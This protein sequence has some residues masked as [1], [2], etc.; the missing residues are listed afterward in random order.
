MRVQFDSTADNPADSEL[1]RVTL[2][3]S[4]PSL[5]KWKIVEE[6]F[7]PHIV[8]RMSLDSNAMLDNDGRPL[9]HFSSFPSVSSS[10]VNVLSQD[11]I[12]EVNPYVFSP[13]NL[14]FPLLN[15][16]L[17]IKTFNYRARN[18]SKLCLMSHFQITCCRF[19]GLM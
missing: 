1:R 15:F 4:K 2:S 13:F 8:D 19:K 16:F 10:G 5:E 7:G 14:I 11:L 12:L 18:E 3:D 17:G 6:I 9:R